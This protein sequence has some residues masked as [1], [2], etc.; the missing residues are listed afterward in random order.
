ML[1]TIEGIDG[2]GKTTT[3]GL[4]AT[5]LSR[6]GYDATHV[7]KRSIT[8]DHP[9]VTRHLS[10]LSR[11]I[12]ADSRGEQIDL[13]GHDHWVYINAAYHCALHK[14]IITPASEQ[15]RILVVD[16]WIYKFAARAS[17]TG[18][19]PVASILDQM[20]HVPAPDL[21][22]MLDVDAAEAFGRRESFTTM[23][24]GGWNGQ[25]TGFVKFQSKVS[26]AL[27]QVAAEQDWH[28]ERPSGRNADTIAADLASS[29]IAPRLVQQVA[30]Q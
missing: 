7:D 1:I 3:A 2:S 14:S 18:D 4:L 22:I 25:T 11:L 5:E 26:E 16:G 8:S 30:A 9:Y 27:K 10:A 13:L 24:K 15:G 21:V 17:V 23:E 28:V 6:L 12:W 20:R 19:L 29:V